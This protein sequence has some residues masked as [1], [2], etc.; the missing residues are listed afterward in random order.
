MTRARSLKPGR[1][2]VEQ[3]QGKLVRVTRGAVFDV[4]VDLRKSSTTFGQWVGTEL[5]D[6]NLEMMWIPPGFAHGFLALSE[7]VDFVYKCTALYAPQFERT[8]VWNDPDI[9]IQW[10]I[11][12]GVVPLIAAK[13]RSARGIRD[14]D[15]FP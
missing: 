7:T 9:S 3:A 4:A 10:P 5:T 15:L 1:P 12:A 8:L 13:D 2:W 6:V 11:P 14:I